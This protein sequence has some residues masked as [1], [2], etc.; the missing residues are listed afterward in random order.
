MHG[1]EI[2]L[3]CVCDV[4]KYLSRTDVVLGEIKNTATVCSRRTETMSD[5]VIVAAPVKSIVHIIIII[6]TMN[7]NTY[8]VIIIGIDIIVVRHHRRRK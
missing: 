1:R 7:V 4:E 5:C 2:S 3:E 6:I 8:I